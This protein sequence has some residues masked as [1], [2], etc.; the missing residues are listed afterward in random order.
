MTIIRNF[1]VH[2]R[3]NQELQIKQL[4]LLRKQILKRILVLKWNSMITTVNHLNKLKSRRKLKLLHYKILRI[5]I[6]VLK[7]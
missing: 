7:G 2:R 3:I 6:I 1:L 5:I 4:V